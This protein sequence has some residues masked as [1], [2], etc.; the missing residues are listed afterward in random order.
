MKLSN[1]GAMLNPVIPAD[2]AGGLPRRELGLSVLLSALFPPILLLA[3]WQSKSFRQRHWLLTL[4]VG[5]YAVSIPIA[6]DITGQ[7]ADGAVH[8]AR[9]YYLYG[10]MP[11]GQFFYELGQLLLFRSGQT[12]HDVF[13]H[14][15]SYF[16]GSVVG[17]PEL[18]FPLVGL[19]YG[20]F[21]VGSMLIIFRDLGKSKLPWVVIFLILCFFLTRNI[22]S[23]Q[24]V[25]NPTAGW[26]LIYG[27]LRY[28]ETRRLRYVFLMA[29]TPLVHFS[30]LLLTLPAVLTVLIGD[31]RLLFAVVFALSL[32]MGFV[33]PDDAIEL[34]SQ[35]E[36]GEQKVLDRREGG[37][38]TAEL[39]AQVLGE[40]MGGGT[41][42]WRAYMVAGYQRYALDI[43]VFGLMISGAYFV[44]DRRSAAVFSTGLMFLAASNTLWFLGG[45]TGRLWG[46]GFLLVM[47]GFLLW[48]LGP[49]FSLKRMFSG[50]LYV[51]S[52]Y[53]S[54][55]AFI[56]YLLFCTSR[57]LEF[58]NVYLLAL[59]WLARILPDGN[60]TFKEVLRFILPI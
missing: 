10:D 23:L 47:A 14:V 53:A 26:M 8:L 21:F 41:R 45:A 4:F 25:R 48:R 43:L 18:F 17:V 59:P 51:L 58:L 39:R 38:A 50:K 40:A 52:C 49:D 36:I 34:I 20:Y 12:S 19:F 56:P 13:I 54:A 55:I 33:N 9:V 44:M 15:L 7:G 30:F 37:R 28:Y 3:A 1:Q 11:F 32:P 16:T 60:L 42:L 6:F 24:A 27:V 35:V 2:S 29:A 5:W 46:L 57:I 31:R 22:E